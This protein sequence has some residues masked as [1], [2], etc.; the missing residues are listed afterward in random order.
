M[1]D[2]DLIDAINVDHLQ[3]KNKEY[4]F[5]GWHQIAVSSVGLEAQ[6][7]FNFKVPIVMSLDDSIFMLHFKIDDYTIPVNHLYAVE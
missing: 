3:I 7:S 4:F 2:N 5:H 6:V 1:S